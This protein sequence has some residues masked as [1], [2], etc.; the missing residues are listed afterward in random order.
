MLYTAGLRVACAKK[1]FH[2]TA[3]ADGVAATVTAAVTAAV[4]ADACVRSLSQFIVDFAQRKTQTHSLAGEYKV[5]TAG[6]RRNACSIESGES[7]TE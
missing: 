3:D 4:A 5:S 2:E 7:P 1:R 6:K